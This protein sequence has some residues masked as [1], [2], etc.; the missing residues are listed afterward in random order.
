MLRIYGRHDPA[1]NAGK[2]P[3]RSFRTSWAPFNAAPEGTVPT[4]D[5]FALDYYYNSPGRQSGS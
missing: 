1:T 4:M 3:T 5:G 2:L